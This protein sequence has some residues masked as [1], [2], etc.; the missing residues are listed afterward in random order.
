MN[1]DTSPVPLP[2]M[3]AR[4]V[5]PAVPPRLNDPGPGPRVPIYYLRLKVTVTVMITGTGTELSSVGV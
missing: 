5:A 4:P 3:S 2:A 1:G